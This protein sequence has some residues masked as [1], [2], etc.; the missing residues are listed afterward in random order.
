[1]TSNASDL[2]A[3][4][5]S[6]VAYLRSPR[7]IRDRAE[8]L[9]ALGLRGDLLHFDVDETRLP[10]VAERVVRVTRAAYP[11]IRSIPYHARFRHFGA[12]G[13]DR[14]ALLDQRLATLGAD[15]RLCSKF[16]LAI[17]SV[18][19][20]AGAGGAWTYHEASGGKYTRSEGLAVASYHLF[21][22]GGLSRDPEHAPLRADAE[23][24]ARITE[25]DLALAF[26]VRADNPLIGL[27]GRAS[28]LRQLGEV[29][30]RN[31]GYFRAES[32]RLGSLALHL[33]SLAKDRTLR[34]TAVLAAVLDAF[35]DIWP[36]RETC[37]GKNLGD[38][39][40]HPRV[41]RVPLHKLSQWLTYSLV[42]P[43][44]ERDIAITGLNELTGLAEYRNG[45]LFVDSGVLVPREPA[46]TE[47]THEVSSTVIIEWRA[48]TV[49][50]LDRTATEVRRLLGLSAEELPLAK[51]LE[52]GTWSAGREIAREKRPDGTPPIRVR[53][54]GT[55]F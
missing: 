6:E 9:Y 15:E 10:S 30:Q 13:K 24:L 2:R 25:Q 48:L 21:A 5:L 50:L 39:W 19:L 16:E 35:G 17:T 18:L 45:G 51:V 29:V 36:G 14:V 42:E 53:S 47:D 52:G 43:L 27:H 46:V 23:V 40:T 1:V 22:N 3:A 12:G 28:L 7:A 55:V 38:V 4:E 33:V 54:D 41:G 31:P 37:G 11:D 44:E 20:D 32:T 49:A 34:A 8:A 26:Q